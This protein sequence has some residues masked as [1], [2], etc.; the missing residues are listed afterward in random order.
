MN[1]D[2]YK[3]HYCNLK[4]GQPL[5]RGFRGSTDI[6]IDK[7]KINTCRPQN[8][9]NVCCDDDL[10]L[11]PGKYIIIHLWLPL[12]TNWLFAPALLEDLKSQPFFKPFFK[13]WKTSSQ[14]SNHLLAG[15]N[16]FILKY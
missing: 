9:I 7:Q 2:L 8:K 1:L 4:R 12:N 10:L 11:H 16:F 15:Y 3:R 6:I 5:Y 14:G 13:T